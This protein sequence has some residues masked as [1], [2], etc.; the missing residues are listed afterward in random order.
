MAQVTLDRAVY[1]GNDHI[2]TV[3]GL[4]DGIAGTYYDD[5][6]GSLSVTV[7]DESGDALSGVSWPVALSY[8]AASQGVF[9]ATLPSEMS[10]EEG[11]NLVAHVTGTLGGF[12]VDIRRKL[13]GRLRTGDE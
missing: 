1:L 7:K 4:R 6:D 13:I 2:L 8:V 11:D 5:G 10:F 12:D 3:S 9:R